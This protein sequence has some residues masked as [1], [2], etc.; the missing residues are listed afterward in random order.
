MTINDT[1]HM[2]FQIGIIIAIV[3]LYLRTVKEKE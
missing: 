3:V 1:G 2:L